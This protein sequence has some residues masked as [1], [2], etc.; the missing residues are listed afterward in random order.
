MKSLSNVSQSY[1]AGNEG[2]LSAQTQ[3]L[4]SPRKPFPS[5][6]PHLFLA[7]E[8]VFLTWRPHIPMG[9]TERI[10]RGL[11]IW[12]GKKLHLYFQNSFT[13]SSHFL[14]LYSWAT[15]HSISSSIYD[16]VTKRNDNFT[17]HYT[18]ADISKYY[19][20][21]PL[22]QNHGSSSTCPPRSHD[23]NL[24]V[25]RLSCEIASQVWS[26]SAQLLLSHQTVRLHVLELVTE[27]ST[28]PRFCQP[29]PSQTITPSWFSSAATQLLLPGSPLQPPQLS[30]TYTQLSPSLAYT[31]YTAWFYASLSL[32][33]MLYLIFSKYISPPLS[34][35]LRLFQ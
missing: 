4:W 16:F 13:E 11:W 3:V 28:T 22:F 24:P 32:C 19:L 17:S 9:P 5:T 21:S 14:Q 20:H 1:S 35:D 31:V 25:Y 7:R 15:N 6:R 2:P 34:P 33:I 12:M 10:Q 29:S 27:A 8:Q 23:C 30:P 26:N 18:V